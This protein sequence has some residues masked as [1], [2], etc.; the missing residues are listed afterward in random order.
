MKGKLR[1]LPSMLRTDQ[2]VCYDSGNLDVS[3]LFSYQAK[4]TKKSNHSY[5]FASCTSLICGSK[6]MSSILSAS[7]RTINEILEREVFPCCK[8]S[9]NLP[10]VA[11]ITSTPARS[12]DP[13]HRMQHQKQ[14][15]QILVNLMKIIYHHNNT[16]KQGSKRHSTLLAK[17]IKWCIGVQT[18]IAKNSILTKIQNFSYIPKTRQFCFYST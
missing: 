11:T 15:K 12:S 10:G 2:W 7:S 9:I 17:K 3:Y 13:C 1:Y 5:A 14:N 16:R 18:C 6:P 8:W 4:W